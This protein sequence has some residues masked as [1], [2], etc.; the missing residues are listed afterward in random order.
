MLP[1]LNIQH[2]PPRQPP[3]SN[4][5][6]GADGS[7]NAPQAAVSYNTLKFDSIEE[8]EAFMG[9]SMHPLAM[10]GLVDV[11]IGCY[12]G[13]VADCFA[14]VFAFVVVHNPLG[15][16]AII[17]CDRGQPCQTYSGSH[18]ERELRGQLEDMQITWPQFVALHAKNHPGVSM[19][20][21]AR[22]WAESKLF[23]ASV[24]V[25][26]DDAVP[27]FKLSTLE[28][29]YHRLA[30]VCIANDTLRSTI[31]RLFTTITFDQQ[32]YPICWMVSVVWL[33]ALLPRLTGRG[34]ADLGGF[35]ASVVNAKTVE[36]W[37]AQIEKSMTTRNVYRTWR[38]PRDVVDAYTKRAN[39]PF[40]LTKTSE[41]GF[42]FELLEAAL[43]AVGITLLQSAEGVARRG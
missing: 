1:F 35:V 8:F 38:M 41:G 42:A 6:R 16:S 14:H 32:Q 9:A 10:G 2:T 30:T 40:D 23:R 24:T 19:R 15:T 29:I 26:L 12:D 7:D 37:I 17:A 36:K 18:I 13:A 34:E 28:S 11:F 39:A 25:L 5:S 43:R 33:L 20:D 27:R 31:G 4:A 21:K 3:H 22:A